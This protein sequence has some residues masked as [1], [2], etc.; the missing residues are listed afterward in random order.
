MKKIKVHS[1]LF[2]ILAIILLAFSV[3]MLTAVDFGISMIVAPAFLLS[4]KLG[5]LTF[6]TTSL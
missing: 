5:F 4:E 6:G 1:E 2:Y 3:A